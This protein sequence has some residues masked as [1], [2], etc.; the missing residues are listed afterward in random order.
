LI[1][2]NAELRRENAYL[3]EEVERLRQENES[4]RRSAV[5]LPPSLTPA[6][7]WIN[8][9]SGFLPSW[10]LTRSQSARSV[11]ARPSPTAHWML[12]WCRA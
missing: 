4:L 3:G 2:E 7:A 9:G 5:T 10:A 8:G 6:K 1:D 12:G 11:A